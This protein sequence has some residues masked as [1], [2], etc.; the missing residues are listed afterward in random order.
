MD[1]REDGEPD[2]VLPVDGSLIER[3]YHECRLSENGETI[4]GVGVVYGDVANIGG[5][6]K[7]RFEAGSLR[8]DD[9]SLNVQHDRRRPI[10][11][12]EGG[13]LKLS[14]GPAQLDVWA[15]PVMT[16]HARDAMLMLRHRLL[17]G[18]SLEFIATAERFEKD[19]RIVESARVVGIG[20]VDRPAYGD[21]V[22]QVAKRFAA[23]QEARRRRWL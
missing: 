13:T 23:V 5:V 11:R 22:A 20:L 21:S 8:F 3:R 14:D 12:T 1:I 9:V 10:A 2:I 15:K 16:G 7:E 17:S 19:L 18:F 6:F 4:V